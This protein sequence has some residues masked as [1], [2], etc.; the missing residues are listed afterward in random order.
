MR[1]KILD[2]VS[3][4][5][6]LASDDETIAGYTV[7]G[8]YYMGYCLVPGDLDLRNIDVGGCLE[9]T[10]HRIIEKDEKDPAFCGYSTDEAVAA[11]ML[12]DKDPAEE[13]EEEIEIDL[14]YRIHGPLL[15]F[16]LV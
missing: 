2:E 7:A 13:D 5:R 16:D 1:E 14:G 15:T 11:V 3:F 8:S 12:A 9:E 10:L 4:L 6:K